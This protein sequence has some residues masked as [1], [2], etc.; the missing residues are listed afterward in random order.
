MSRVLTSQCRW[1]CGRVDLGRDG[2]L[3]KWRS[4]Q[5]HVSHRNYAYDDATHARTPGFRDDPSRVWEEVSSCASRHDGWLTVTNSLAMDLVS[6]PDETKVV[7]VSDH[8]DKNGNSKLVEECSLPLTGVRCVSQMITDLVR[9]SA[10]RLLD[11]LRLT[12]HTLQGVFDFDRAGT[13]TLV[14]LQPGVTLDE[15]RSKT[16]AHFEVASDLMS[17]DEA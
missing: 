7:I 15:V 13:C 6:N 10:L 5:L 2:S 3:A 14:E 8:L 4:C 17:T 16:G 9:P 1:P 12:R 11:C